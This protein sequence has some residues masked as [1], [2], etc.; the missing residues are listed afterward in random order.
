MASCWNT[1]SWRGIK[2]TPSAFITAA[3][4]FRS[5]GAL[6]STGSQL[7][8]GSS[9]PVGNL[10]Q[11]LYP[12]PSST[13]IAEEASPHMQKKAIIG[14]VLLPTAKQ[15][16][17][18]MRNSSSRQLLTISRSANCEVGKSRSPEILYSRKLVQVLI[19]SFSSSAYLAYSIRHHRNNTSF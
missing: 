1:N 5:K 15:T 6:W 4:S 16:Y 7:H 18:H 12:P 17:H 9:F 13:V 10:L 2:E 3:W 19:H 11:T 8:I 14:T